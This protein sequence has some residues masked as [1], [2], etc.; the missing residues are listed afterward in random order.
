MA[1]PQQPPPPPQTGMS[2]SNNSHVA[3]ATYPIPHPVA[4]LLQVAI[5]GNPGATATL[6]G[7]G[8]LPSVTSSAPLVSLQIESLEQALSLLLEN[9]VDALDRLYFS[10]Y[11]SIIWQISMHDRSWCVRQIWVFAFPHTFMIKLLSIIFNRSPALR[12][13]PLFMRRLQLR[14]ATD[15]Q[16]RTLTLTDLGVG[17]TRADLIN[18]L[19]IGR[20]SHAA[21]RWYQQ[22][23]STQQQ[24]QEQVSNDTN[25]N[26]D[27]TDMEQAPEQH[28]VTTTTSDTEVAPDKQLTHEDEQQDDDNNDFVNDD[29]D[30]ATND[31]DSYRYSP[32]NNTPATSEDDDDDEE[33]EFD[34]A[35]DEEDEE[36]DDNENNG[37]AMEEGSSDVIPCKASDLGGFYGALAALGIG[38]QV[39]TK[40]NESV[41]VRK[42]S[43]YNVIDLASQLPPLCQAKD[44]DYYEFSVGMTDEWLANTANPSDDDKRRSLQEFRIIRPFSEGTRL[45]D[46]WVDLD[47]T[48]Q[49]VQVHGESGTRVTIVLHD[50]AVAAGLLDESVLQPIITKLLE[51]KTQYT[52]AFS[53]TADPSSWMIVEDEDDKSNDDDA[54]AIVESSNVVNNIQD[55]REVLE[56][57]ETTTI[58]SI[59]KGKWLFTLSL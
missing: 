53:Q 50:Q 43:F 51:S 15:R 6:S 14:I 48:K 38:V 20:T 32:V 12:K 37:S 39:G 10:T 11:V 4:C 30:K 47:A 18:A 45:D 2:N 3:R 29:A 22:Y 56:S 25:N 58:S 5:L 26:T 24:Q 8:E 1:T 46:C 21:R 7:H 36:D 16:R 19:G 31:S 52:V 49:F 59:D 27:N 28:K 35:D 33:E 54:D 23:S 42:S 9:S 13:R 41:C 57:M 17:M 44:D 40:V 34:D 55:E